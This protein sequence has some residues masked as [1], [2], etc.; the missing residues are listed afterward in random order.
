MRIRSSALTCAALL[1]ALALAAPRAEAL[2]VTA[3]SLS[4]SPVHSKGPCPA[5]FTFTGKVELNG[6]GRFTYKWERSDGAID[7]TAPHGATYNGSTPTIVSETWTLGAPG[8][9]FHPFHG[10]VKLHVLTPNDKVSNEAKFTLDCGGGTTPVGGPVTGGG[11]THPG[12]PTPV[13]GPTN[14]RCDGKPDLVPMLHTPMDGWVAVKNIGA[15]NAGPSR[16]F[17]KCVKDGYAGPGGGCVDAPASGISAPFFPTP[18]A[19]GLNVPALAC[20]AEFSAVMPWWSN[21]SWPKGTYRF[22]ATADATGAVAES[23]E[24]NNQTTSTLVK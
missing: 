17:I 9:L 15:G 20:G 2:S 5:V 10:W 3:V 16:L 14:P 6:R 1:T 4:V 18:D 11:T 12:N 23:N 8:P 22:T 24:A 19:L 7:S 13:G 21:T